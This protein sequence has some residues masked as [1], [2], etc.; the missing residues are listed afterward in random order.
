MSGVPDLPPHS[1]G[2]LFLTTETRDGRVTGLSD[3][4]GQKAHAPALP[5]HRRLLLLPRDDRGLDD[6]RDWWRYLRLA[7]KV[8]IHQVVDELVVS[9]ADLFQAMRRVFGDEL[10]GGGSASRAEVVRRQPFELGLGREE[11]VFSG[12][13]DLFDVADGVLISQV[14][15]QAIGQAEIPLRLAPVDSGEIGRLAPRVGQSGDSR[16]DR[17]EAACIRRPVGEP[18]AVADRRRQPRNSAMKT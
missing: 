8:S 3:A 16:I 7:Y 9:I 17:H 5:E 18:E 11:P 12:L 4:G 13:D 15:R 1:Q 6:R 14:V 2:R 10:L